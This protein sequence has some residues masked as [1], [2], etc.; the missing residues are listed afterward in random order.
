MKTITDPVGAGA[1]RPT[2]A[3]RMRTA[4]SFAHLVSLSRPKRAKA[5]PVQVKRPASPRPDPDAELMGGPAWAI[6]ARGR[7]RARCQTILD[8][9]AGRAHPAMARALAFMT[10]A[11]EAEALEL[12]A[13][14]PALAVRYVMRQ[15]QPTREAVAS[16]LDRAFA[17]AGAA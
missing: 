7:E 14:Q 4:H 5:A 9:P 13:A 8:S 6:A 12:L 15:R 11:T 2:I 10:R 17:R 16:S 1:T 3:E